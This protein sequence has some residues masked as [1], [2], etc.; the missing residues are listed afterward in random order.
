[1][2]AG[3]LDNRR[4]N[5]G[6]FADIIG[7]QDKQFSNKVADKLDHSSQLPRKRQPDN[8]SMPFPKNAAPYSTNYFIFD[9]LMITNCE[10]PYYHFDK[11]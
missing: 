7:M 8:I 6:T 11:T 4:L 10:E 5:S 1:M 3:Y 9:I 2:G